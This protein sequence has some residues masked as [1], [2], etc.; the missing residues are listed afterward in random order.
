MTCYAYEGTHYLRGRHYDGCEDATCSGCEQCSARHCPE[1]RKG[2]HL[3]FGEA[4]C[5]DCIGATRK[6]LRTLVDLC[7]ALPEEA[8]I[9]GVGSEAANLSGPFADPEAFAWRRAARA[10]RE[11]V[12]LSS[13]EPDDEHHPRS[14]LKRW[15]QALCEDYGDDYDRGDDIASL[16]DWLDARLGRIANDVGQDF[17]LFKA[18]VRRCRAH[19]EAVLHDGEQRDT[20]APCLECRVPLVREWGKL[21]AAD[22][23][24]CPRCREFRTDEDYRRNVADLHTAK[25]THLT[26]RDMEI[27]TGVKA[28]TVRVW[29]NRGDVERKRESGRTVYA[30]ADV[31][32]IVERRKL[33]S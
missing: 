33:V 16:T 7:A 17:G 31:L 24:R 13:L 9:R 8:E 32:E 19:L 21:A 6:D 10:A 5:P 4:T 11:D 29:A 12:L 25:A 15:I 22:G 2:T 18:E 26:D 23:W 20:G 14:V 28:G 30:V 1:C 27:R 3:G